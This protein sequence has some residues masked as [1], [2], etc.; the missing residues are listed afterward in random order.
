MLFLRSQTQL[1]FYLLVIHCCSHSIQVDLCEYSNRSYKCGDICVG[2]KVTSAQDFRCECD[3]ITLKYEHTPTHHCCSETNCKLSG[4][5]VSCPGGRVLEITEPCLGR[6]YA[7][8]KS[9]DNLA[10]FKSQYTCTGQEECLP[11]NRMCQGQSFCGDNRVCDEELRCGQSKTS[12][13]RRVNLSQTDIIIEHSYC[14]DSLHEGNSVYNRIDRSDEEATNTLYKHHVT[15]IDYSYFT[16]CVYSRGPGVTCHQTRDMSDSLEACKHV[17]W[18][19]RLDRDS[20]CVTNKDGDR[21]SRND[22]T[23]CQNKTFWRTIGTDWLVSNIKD[24]SGVRCNGSLMQTI[25]PW[26]KYYNGKPD[27]RL[28][29]QCEDKSDRVFALRQP[30]QNKTFYISIHNSEWC[31]DSR[32]KNESICTDHSSWFADYQDQTN[33]H[34]SHS[35]QDSCAKPGP[36][37]LSCTN[38]NYFMCSRSNHCVHAD[39]KCDGHPQCPDN[40]DEDFYLCKHEYFRKRIVEPFASFKCNSTMYPNTFTITTA[41]NNIHE[42]LNGTDE[43]LCAIDAKTT[44]VQVCV[45]FWVFG[46]FILLKIPHLIEYQNG[47]KRQ[48]QISK[49]DE[50]RHFHVLIQTLKENSGDK[51]NNGKLNSYLL[52]ILYSKETSIIKETLVNFYDILADLFDY[53]EAEIFLYLKSNIHPDVTTCIV[54]HK[55]RGLKTKIIEFIEDNSGSKKITEFLDKVTATPS[56]RM[57][58]SSLGAIVSILF[59]FLDIVKDI[60]LS[61]ALLIIIGGPSSITEFPFQFSSAV[62]LCWIVSIIVPI[63][64]SSINLALTQPFLVFTSTRLRAMRGG[65]VVAALGCL[66][67]SPLNTVVLKTNLEK[68]EQRAIEAA[69]DQSDITLDLFQECHVIASNLHKY[70]QVELG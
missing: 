42:C 70:H 11:I 61:V 48:E 36:N 30:C 59:H 4:N 26:Y 29:Q 54:Q 50:D 55:F 28:K 56:L 3:N 35:C 60:S 6:C 9:S 43:E 52:Y 8:Y 21:I 49:S 32:V 41:C 15:L 66:L 58:F 39:L 25:Y 27:P 1:Y 40:E 37:C 68:T 65:R 63:L 69:R 67:L 33:L 19:C 16:P 13:F 53:E 12:D 7:D 22:E 24:G 23:L 20:T 34:D 57:K 46:L 45:I 51:K 18:W 44:P 10:F 31:S 62:V 2:K 5:S 38:E 64:A 14:H 47:S 17:A